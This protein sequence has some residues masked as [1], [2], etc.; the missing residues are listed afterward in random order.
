MLDISV[1]THDIQHINENDSPVNYICILW[2]EQ[3][4]KQVKDSK[5]NE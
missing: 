4:M 1:V 3:V 2:V 5:N